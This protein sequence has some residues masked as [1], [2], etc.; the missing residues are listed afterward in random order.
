[1]SLT[2]LFIAAGLILF[3]ILGSCV[4]W[5]NVKYQKK[6]KQQTSFIT[7]IISAC[8]SGIIVYLLYSKWILDIYLAF[9]A[10]GLIGTVGSQGIEKII[11]FLMNLVLNIVS[12]NLGVDKV[13]QYVDFSDNKDETKE[14]KPVVKQ[15][16]APKNNSP[17]STMFPNKR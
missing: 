17:P 11:K 12:R 10:A 7:E 6:K 8:F 3:T 1:M 5:F 15:L 9:I 2:D 16:E 4:K 13:E 14:D